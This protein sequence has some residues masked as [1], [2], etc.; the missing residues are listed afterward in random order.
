MAGGGRAGASPPPGS[1]R[2]RKGGDSGTRCP[3]SSDGFRNCRLAS[4]SARSRVSAREGGQASSEF[5][6]PLWLVPGTSCLFCSLLPRLGH[7]LL[8]EQQA[9]G[10]LAVRPSA[11]VAVPLP[12]PP[13]ERE[14]SPPRPPNLCLPEQG[15]VSGTG[16]EAGGQERPRRKQLPAHPEAG[17]LPHA[18][19]EGVTW[20][21]VQCAVCVRVHTSGVQ[22][23]IWWA[24]MCPWTCERRIGMYVV[25]V[26]MVCARV[27]VS[28]VQ[29]CMWHACVCKGCAHVHVRGV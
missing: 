16:R 2:L 25:C 18:G 4:A 12:G 14:A 15:T 20:G 17:Q 23:C 8:P 5:R 6:A 9:P 24:P 19:G 29:V 21:A 28:G 26:C 27:H 13:R 10:R 11:L 1:R 3:R 22:A 7:V